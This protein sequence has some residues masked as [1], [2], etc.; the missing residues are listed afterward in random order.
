MKNRKSNLPLSEQVEIL[1]LANK[2]L[3]NYAN[4]LEEK[5]GKYERIMRHC[6]RFQMEQRAAEPRHT[7]VYDE[8]YE[9]VEADFIDDDWDGLEESD[10]IDDWEEDDFDE[11]DFDE[12]A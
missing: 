3:R 10:F 12:D 7:D 9:D 5:I 11:E 6:P 2:T 8:F 4:R 1:E